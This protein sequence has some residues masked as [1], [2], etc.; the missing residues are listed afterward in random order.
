MPRRSCPLPCGLFG[1]QPLISL[2]WF[3][4]K[5]NENMPCFHLPLLKEGKESLLSCP[6]AESKCSGNFTY[7]QSS[8]IYFIYTVD[9][10]NRLWITK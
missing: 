4:D 9:E 2:G 1:Q 10:D 7:T 3:S 8:D 5:D 6:V